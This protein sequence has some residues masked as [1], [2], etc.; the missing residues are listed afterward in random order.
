MQNTFLDEL[1]QKLYDNGFDDA[2]IGLCLDYSKR[3][4]ANR[5]P[6]IFDKI[7]LSML[8]GMEV[9]E[10]TVL[11]KSI[12]NQYTIRNIPKKN[13]DTRELYIPSLK[14]K[15]IQ[16]WILDE[17]LYNIKVSPYCTGFM[18]EKSILEN[19]RIHENKACVMNL[20]IR[21][22]FPSIRFESIYRVFYYYGY[23][24]EV[25]YYLARLCTVHNFLPQG[26]PT[27]PYLSNIVC[28]RLDKRLSSLA[29]KYDANYSRYADDI[30]LSGTGSSI[31]PR[32]PLIKI[33][34]DSEGF[35]I[36]YKKVRVQKQ[37]ERQIVTGLVVNNK[38]RV[39]REVER[40]LRQQ[41]YY[42][43]KF[44]VNEHLKRKKKNKLSGFKEHLYGLAMFIKMIDNRK[45][46]RYVSDL[47]EISWD[48]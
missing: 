32:L 37:Q 34:L 36:N 40:E 11:V 27:S 29:S 35:K 12:E 43:K 47:N 23:T 46:E 19:A 14:L 28:L 39:P 10:L 20:D 24:S 7:H 18:K 26:A 5:L 33:I 38:A 3:L 13:G 8:F 42:C 44:G 17:I 30:T 16:R 22:F 1:K 41:I 45:G 48:Y 21:N 31:V 15:E 25:S 2:Y 6:V 4:I 9:K